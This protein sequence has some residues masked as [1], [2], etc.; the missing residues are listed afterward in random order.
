ME[1]IWTIFT[2][3]ISTFSPKSSLEIVLA[4]KN[5]TRVN[6]CFRAIE[7]YYS[8]LTSFEGQGVNWRRPL[9]IIRSWFSPSTIFGLYSIDFNFVDNAELSFW[10]FRPASSFQNK[11]RCVISACRDIWR[12]Y[13]SVF[14]K[15]GSLRSL[16]REGSP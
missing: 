6:W 10:A 8:L 14:C 16:T 7:G 15:F 3:S 2:R 11:S 13:P 1:K 9:I 12:T 4:P 5:K